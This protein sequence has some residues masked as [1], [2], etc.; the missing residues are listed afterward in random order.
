MHWFLL[1]SPR[2]T[3]EINPKDL[4][5]Q[6]VQYFQFLQYEPFHN[7]PTTPLVRTRKQHCTLDAS[8]HA[9][10]QMHLLPANAC[11][12]ARESRAWAGWESPVPRHLTAQPARGLSWPWITRIPPMTQH[13]GN[14]CHLRVF[15]HLHFSFPKDKP[16]TLWLVGRK[17]RWSLE[18][19]ARF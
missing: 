5:G 3:G 18:F 10:A 13:F 6:S 19:P 17:K 7:T 15:L 11:G 1:L 12:P 16:V 8:A 2:R 14:F 9:C 4:K